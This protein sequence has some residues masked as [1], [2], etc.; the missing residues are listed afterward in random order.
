MCESN[1]VAKERKKWFDMVNVI[2]Q[3]LVCLKLNSVKLHIML[4]IFSNR[5]SYNGCKILMRTT[6]KIFQNV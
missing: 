2:L 1:G 3:V 4:A 6:F 5:V